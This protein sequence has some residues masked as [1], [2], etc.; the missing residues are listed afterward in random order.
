MIVA[1]KTANLQGVFGSNVC[2]KQPV[3]GAPPQLGRGEAVGNPGLLADI[4]DLEKE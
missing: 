4:G 1:L 3:A 2:A